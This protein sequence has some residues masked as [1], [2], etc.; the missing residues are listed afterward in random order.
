MRDWLTSQR[1]RGAVRRGSD[2]TPAT[3]LHSVPLRVGPVVDVSTADRLGGPNARPYPGPGWGVGA[4]H[5]VVV[6][7]KKHG[8][9]DLFVV[10]VQFDVVQTVDDAVDEFDPKGPVVRR[11]VDPPPPRRPRIPS[12]GVLQGRFPVKGPSV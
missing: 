3:R 12:V 9:P 10:F 7:P 6:K 11:D 1:G 2:H 8:H 5:E 4:S